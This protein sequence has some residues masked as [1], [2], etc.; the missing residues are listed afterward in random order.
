M[1]S[2]FINIAQLCGQKEEERIRRN[3]H[4]V[5]KTRHLHVLRVDYHLILGVIS[6]QTDCDSYSPRVG[7]VLLASGTSGTLLSDPVVIVCAF[8]SLLSTLSNR[9]RRMTAH[10]HP[11]P[12]LTI[13]AA[14]SLLLRTPWCFCLTAV[15]IKHP[16]PV[17][18]TVTAIS[19]HLLQSI[20]LAG[21]VGCWEA[22]TLRPSAFTVAQ[23]CV[24][25][26]DGP[27]LSMQS[28]FQFSGG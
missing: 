9:G 21:L 4:S 15:L 27:S 12:A 8:P 2:S 14:S 23:L 16:L 19:I 20:A 28:Q 3:S 7:S 22:H 10:P 6:D 24:Y 17:S 13:N 1:T 11:A 25:Y 26:L 5:K 18:V